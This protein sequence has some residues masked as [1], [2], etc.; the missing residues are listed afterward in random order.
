MIRVRAMVPSGLA[1]AFPFRRSLGRP[2]KGCRNTLTGRTRMSSSSG[3]E[4][5]VPS[6]RQDFDGSWV[7]N[8]LEFQ[9]DADGSWVR[10]QEGRLAVHEDELNGYQVRRYR[11][12][13][14]GL[15]ARIERW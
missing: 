14:E 9:R 1:E 12:R 13:V 10:D 4:D 11:P 3:A 7:A 8:H 15:F 6:Y 2:T 5:L